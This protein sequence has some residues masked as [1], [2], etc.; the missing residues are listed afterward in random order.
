MIP[1]L[2]YYLQFQRILQVCLKN[3]SDQFSLI[4]H[5][6]YFI[7]SLL[8]QNLDPKIHHSQL[9]TKAYNFYYK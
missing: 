2:L 7:F 6:G 9:Q 8:F 4:L 3:L 1:T 5:N